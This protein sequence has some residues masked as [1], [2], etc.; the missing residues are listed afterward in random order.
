MVYV[1]PDDAILPIV[2]KYFDMN[3]NDQEIVNFVL[4]DIDQ[5]KYGFR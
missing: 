4:K 2:R 1:A 5:D 3:R